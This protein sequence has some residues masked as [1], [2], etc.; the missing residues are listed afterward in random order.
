MTRERPLESRIGL[1]APR[2]STTRNVHSLRRMFHVKLFRLCTSFSAVERP[3]CRR[4]GDQHRWIT[5][6]IHSSVNTVD[7]RGN[8][9]ISADLGCIRCCGAESCPP[10]STGL[11]DNP[12]LRIWTLPNGHERLDLQSRARSRGNA[13]SANLSIWCSTATLAQRDRPRGFRNAAHR[14]LPGMFHVKHPR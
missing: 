13:E 5:F 14:E 3:S 4:R 7:D 10:L 1:G 12:P 9:R 8:P 2:V 11:V 6:S